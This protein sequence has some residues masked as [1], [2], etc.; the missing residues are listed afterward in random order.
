MKKLKEIFDR[1]AEQKAKKRKIKKEITDAYALS[2]PWQKVEEEF[3]NVKGRKRQ[4]EQTIDADFQAE[5]KEIDELTESIRADEQ[6]LS[7]AALSAL[8]KGETVELHDKDRDMR[9]EPKFNVRFKQLE[10]L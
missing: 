8:M 10:M 2:A 9:W 1:I 6:L 4:I 7:D 3:T 5:W